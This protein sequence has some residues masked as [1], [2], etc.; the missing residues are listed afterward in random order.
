LEKKAGEEELNAKLSA[1]HADVKRQEA[2]R[3]N[4]EADA[5]EKSVKEFAEKEE[6][7]F[8]RCESGHESDG[9]STVSVAKANESGVA[10]EP[11]CPECDQPTKRIKRSE[12]TGQEKYESDKERKDAEQM[13][14]NHR[15]Q[16]GALAKEV[17]QLE[18]TAQ[19][20][21]GQAERSHL[22]AKET[23]SV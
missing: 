9:P 15:E 7:G 17:S 13:V 20:F 12:M 2:E 18:A 10:T 21:R 23:R 4:A 5:I 8:W 16:A 11:R 6:R 14:K 22:V 3:L 19:H 1:L